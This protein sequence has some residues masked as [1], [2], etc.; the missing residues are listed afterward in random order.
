MIKIIHNKKA[1]LCGLEFNFSNVSYQSSLAYNSLAAGKYS[2]LSSMKKEEFRHIYGVSSFYNL[3]RYNGGRGEGLSL[4]KG[5]LAKIYQAAVAKIFKSSLLRIN[6]YNACGQSFLKALRLTLLKHVALSSFLIM[7]AK[8]V[9][10]ESAL[11]E[12]ACKEL[13]LA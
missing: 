7:Q 1:Y 10:K 12:K 9:K 13:A 2:V 3:G 6:H 5:D 4:L 8:K 11:H